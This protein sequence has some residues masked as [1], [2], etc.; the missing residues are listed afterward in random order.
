MERKPRITLK[1]ARCGGV[2]ERLECQIKLSSGAKARGCF[3]SKKCMEESRKHGSTLQCKQ[4]GKSFY[5][6][7]GEQGGTINSF[8]SLTCRDLFRTEHLKPTTYIKRGGRHYH[9]TAAEKAIGRP[10][11][12]A[13]VV[14]HKDNNKHNNEPHNIIVF[15]SQKEHA[16]FHT[17]RYGIDELSGISGI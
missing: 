13:E 4:C 14:H 3:C 1:C 5:R 6:R 2:F 8:C 11:T 7:Y 9:R 15:P 10:L 12:G 17:G 16:L